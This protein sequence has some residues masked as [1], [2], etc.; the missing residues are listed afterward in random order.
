MFDRDPTILGRAVCL[1]DDPSY[2]VVGILPDTTFPDRKDLWRPLR[3]HPDKDDGGLSPIAVGRLRRGVTFPQARDDLTRIQRGWAQEHP[4]KKVTAMPKVTPIREIQLAL[5]RQVRFAL[6]VVFG[7]V[8][9]VLLIA[10]CNVT[11]TMLARG[12]YRSREVAVR[13]T[14]GATRGR[15][16][17]QVLT[18]S[19]VLSVAGGLLGLLL[20][21]HALRVLL[22]LLAG[23]GFTRDDNRRDSQRTQEIGIRMALGA[24]VQD[25]L[26]MVLRQGLRFILIGLALGLIGGGAS[27]AVSLPVS[28]RGSTASVRTIPRPSGPGRFG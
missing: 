26:T 15:I 28:R 16:I 20:S 4:D 3:T 22:V 10:C 14:L 11:S 2:T 23:R 25:V 8:A 24:R 9:L 6:S 5:V 12:T 21:H 13:V 7:V 1:D 19:L 18:E 17:Q 27:S